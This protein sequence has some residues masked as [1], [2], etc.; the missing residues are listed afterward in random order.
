[1]RLARL[2]SGELIA[3]AGAVALAAL[4]F[5]PWYATPTGDID[6]WQAHVVT[7]VLIAIAIVPAIALAVANVLERSPALPV[8]LE[9]WTTVLAVP[10]CIAIAIS[11][12][13]KPD[14]ATALRPASWLSLIAALA[15]VAGGWQAMRDEHGPLYEPAEPEPRPAPSPPPASGRA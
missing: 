11:L 4:S 2:R 9:V 15:I 10:A 12:L 3:L 5:L 8:A 6:A 1:M 14:H 13:H 7:D